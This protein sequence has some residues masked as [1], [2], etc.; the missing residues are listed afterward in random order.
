MAQ[1]VDDEMENTRALIALLDGR[2]EQFLRAYPSDCM[3]YEFGLGLV[4][5]LRKRLELM[6]A[7]RGDQPRDLSAT[8]GKM[9]AYIKSLVGE[10]A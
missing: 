9:R 1:I 7:H 4:G 2:V 8:L 10:E 5:Q 3:T 6:A